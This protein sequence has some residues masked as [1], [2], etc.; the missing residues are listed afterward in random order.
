MNH[1]P[2][3]LHCPARNDLGSG[4]VIC[5]MTGRQITDQ[6]GYHDPNNCEDGRRLQIQLATERAYQ[7]MKGHLEGRI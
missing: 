2:P 4:M 5:Y 3:C 7:K 1:N 6:T